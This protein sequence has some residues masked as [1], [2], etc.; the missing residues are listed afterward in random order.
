MTTRDKPL[1]KASP[2]PPARAEPPDRLPMPD[3]ARGWA[4]CFIAVANIMLYLHGR[5]YGMRQKIVPDTTAGQIVTFLTV[6][7]VDARV[8]PLFALLVGYGVA[9][10][11]ATRDRGVVRW[12]GIG[13]VLFGAVHGILLFA[14]DVLALYGILTLVLVGMRR[15]TDRTLLIVAAILLVPTALTQGVAFVAGTPAALVAAGFAS[16]TTCPTGV[17][18]SVVHVA[19]GPF[20]GLGYALLTLAVCQSRCFMKS[21]PARALS[22]VGQRSL[23]C[24]LLQSLIMVPLLPAWTLALGAELDATS[25]L[26][27]AVLTYAI[28][29]LVALAL[30]RSGDAKPAEQLLRAIAQRGQRRREA[31][32]GAIA[33]AVT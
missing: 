28:T 27:A 21:R 24:Y 9:R 31:R 14:G 30:R 20:G 25:A 22:A 33:N 6:A 2:Q 12:R 5:E 4:L 1:D 16:A 11:L 15:V 17:V 8:Y 23:T 29:M 10:Q 26:L 32:S 18:F 13:L 19:T 3:I 7:L